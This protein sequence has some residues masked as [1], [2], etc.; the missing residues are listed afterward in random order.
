ML[1]EINRRERKEPR[2]FCRFCVIFRKMVTKMSENSFYILFSVAEMRK[3]LCFLLSLWIFF[4]PVFV[5]EPLNFNGVLD[6]FIFFSCFE[7]QHFGWHDT[8]LMLDFSSCFLFIPKILPSV[9]LFRS[10]RFEITFVPKMEAQKRSLTKIYEVLTSIK[11]Q[12]VTYI[13]IFFSN[14]REKFHIFIFFL[15]LLRL[16]ATATCA[17]GCKSKR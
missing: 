5:L 8:K 4:V 12:K 7:W 13:L 14:A 1:N 9:F 15:L 6:K 11:W 3:I 10:D 2:I 16:F 17:H